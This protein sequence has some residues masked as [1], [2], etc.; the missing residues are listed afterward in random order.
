MEKVKQFLY[1][2]LVGGLGLGFVVLRAGLQSDNFI[3]IG[4]GLLLMV[5]FGGILLARIFFARRQ[6]HKAEDQ[7]KSNLRAFKQRAK[8]IEIDLESADIQSNSWTEEVA[9]GEDQ[10]S[11]L[12]EISGTGKRNL[13]QINQNKQVLSFRVMVDGETKMYSKHVNMDMDTLRL[14]LAVQKTTYLYIDGEEEY[15]DLDFLK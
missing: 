10:Y 14:H 9:A 8:K 1:Y 6:D 11:G 5:V 4:L 13:V 2:I 12:D 3:F 7:R 15:L